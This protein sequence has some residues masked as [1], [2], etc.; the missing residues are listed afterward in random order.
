MLGVAS[1][2]WP[3]LPLI[4]LA[5]AF[6]D[7]PGAVRSSTSFLGQNSFPCLPRLIS[8]CDLLHHNGDACPPQCQKRRNSYDTHTSNL[9]RYLCLRGGCFGGTVDSDSSGWEDDVLEKKGDEKEETSSQEPDDSENPCVS[10]LIL[11]LGPLTVTRRSHGLRSFC[12]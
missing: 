9:L 1:T 4:F 11:S 5:L 6:T 2:M 3:P 10:F 12:L 8:S 7:V